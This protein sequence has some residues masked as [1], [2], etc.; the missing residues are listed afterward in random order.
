MNTPDPAIARATPGEVASSITRAWIA[1]F[2]VVT[3]VGMV[4]SFVIGGIFNFVARSMMDNP[5]AMRMAIWTVSI[6]VNAP[7]SF[8]VFQWAV[9]GKVLPAV[10]DWNAGGGA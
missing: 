5:M 4:L 7:I 1:Y 10:L 6:V 3:V 9:R 8:L 2:L